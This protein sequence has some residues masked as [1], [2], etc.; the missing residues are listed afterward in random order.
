M[1]EASYSSSS[2]DSSLSEYGNT[3]RREPQ[4]RSGSPNRIRHLRRP[5]GFEGYETP[6]MKSMRRSKTGTYRLESPPSEAVNSDDSSI[7]SIYSQSPREEGGG[8]VTRDSP[9]HKNT[10]ASMKMGLSPQRS[11]EKM[12][13]N[14]GSTPH[15]NKSIVSRNLTTGGKNKLR[16]LPSPRSRGFSVSPRGSPTRQAPFKAGTLTLT[17][18]L[19]P[20]P[21]LNP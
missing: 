9:I 14:V 3:R 17:L 7:H 21:N 4:N 2:L 11:L 20:N 18:T 1:E 5:L 13:S 12:T 19:T 15:L 16:R 6:V 8:W 10:V